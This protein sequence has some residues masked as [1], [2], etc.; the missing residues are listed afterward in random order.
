[1]ANLLSIAMQAGEDLGIYVVDEKDRISFDD[2]VFL[3]KDGDKYIVSQIWSEDGDIREHDIGEYTN[4]IQ[5]LTVCFRAVNKRF[6]T[7]TMEGIL[8]Q[9]QENNKKK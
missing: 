2:D 3:Q 4:P 8:C 1:M 5:A 6:V 9:L 7:L